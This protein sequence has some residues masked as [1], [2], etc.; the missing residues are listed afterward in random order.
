MKN[1]RKTF[2]HLI[3]RETSL[4]LRIMAETVARKIVRGD[5]QL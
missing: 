3:E 5:I 1:K 2:V 4:N